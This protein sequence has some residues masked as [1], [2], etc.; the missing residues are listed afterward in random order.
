MPY[1]ASPALLVAALLVIGFGALGLFPNYY[2]FTQDLSRRHQ[3]KVT[4]VLSCLCWLAMAI[5]QKGIGW[6][7]EATGS[8][9]IPFWISGVAPLLAFV[10]L[11]LLW[12][13]V[14][15]PA[16]RTPVGSDDEA[17]AKPGSTTI[18]APGSVVP[19]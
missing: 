3:G 18:Q 2:S 5:W 10:A 13:Q 6:I 11:Q 15:D 8:Y 12:G 4:G 7:V 1:L 19:G 14:E 9:T 16:A 17:T